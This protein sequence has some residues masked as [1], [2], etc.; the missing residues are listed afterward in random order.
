MR[1]RPACL[2]LML[3]VSAQTAP[4]LR[5]EGGPFLPYRINRATAIR[6]E[7]FSGSLELVGL[8]WDGGRVPLSRSEVE[9][10]IQAVALAF[11]L[12]EDIRSL[13]LAARGEAPLRL[14]LAGEPA[15]GAAETDVRK[16]MRGFDPPAH[17]EAAGTPPERFSLGGAD[18][19]MA[20]FQA[21]YAL[22]SLP[23][24]WVPLAPLAGLA[25]VAVVASALGRRGAVL[26]G[27]AALATTLLVVPL[28][29]PR[30]MLY[31]VVFPGEGPETRVS[32]VVERRIEE[33]AGYRQVVYAAGQAEGSVY[34]QAGSAE[35]VGLWAPGG[36]GL[37]VEEV[38]PSEALVRFST[39]PLAISGRGGTRLSA[40][41]FVT[42]W[43]LHARR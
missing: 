7:G 24:S 39:P 23:V 12:D 17:L 13:E 36:T 20:G 11:Y 31:R 43:V 27:V 32:G 22:F 38:V 5:L 25:G 1:F 16:R 42:G 9:G 34:P 2:A 28:A 15:L 40:P 3:S 41:D 37:P 30:P 35:L 19:V 8:R 21:S 6:E 4:G 18:L 33:R 10:R 29:A 26:S 14:D